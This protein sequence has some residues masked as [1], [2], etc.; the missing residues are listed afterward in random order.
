MGAIDLAREPASR[1]NFGPFALDPRR[2]ELTR[3]G[4]AVAL[5]PK[6]F[7]LLMYF[8]RRPGQALSKQ[9]LLAALWP[10]LVVSDD[11]LSQCVNE[12]RSV[13]DD[14][15]QGIIKTVSR[16]GY[17]FD[18]VVSAIADGADRIASQG[19]R[20]ASISASSDTRDVAA[21]LDG[22]SPAAVA[23]DAP[24][25]RAR[26]LLYA[27]G[28]GIAVAVMVTAALLLWMRKAP[29]GSIDDAVWARR[30]MAVIPFVEQG[31]GTGDYFAEAIT[32]DLVADLA[33]LPQTY[34]VA[35]ASAAAVRARETDI[36]KIGR[37]LG[38]RY[39]LSGSVR[40]QGAAVRLSAQ[41]AA[42]DNGAVLWSE[43]FDYPNAADWAWERDIGL[44]IART[45]D[46][47][48][49]AVA[50]PARSRSG[51]HLEA[52]DAVMRGAY[53][54]RHS[55]ARED[56][57]Q[58][59]SDFE[60][61]LKI[62]PDSPGALSGY[63]LAT[64]SWVTSRY[65]IDPKGDI[66]LAAKAI[67]RALTIDPDY[68]LAHFA[69]GHVLFM[70]GDLDGALGEYQRVIASNPSDA[71]SHA[72]IGLVMLALGRLEEV[73]PQIALA[74]RLNPL[75]G[76]QVSFGHYVAGVAEFQLGHEDAAYDRMRKAVTA[77]PNLIQGWA[78]MAAID[79]LQGRQAQATAEVDEIRRRR[80]NLTIRSV[81]GSNGERPPAA[82]LQRGD[83]R[84]I[85][86]L[87][88]AGLPE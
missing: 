52:V 27:A 74:Q 82:R 40:R 18:A 34:V 76:L 47:R 80:P 9:E 26:R 6:T 5:R 66:Q 56:L 32:E 59:R 38:V 14:R 25:H 30:S 77:N 41:F 55:A 20:T 58:A 11:S 65:S 63:A 31:E 62:D 61:A 19:D 69:H 64:L 75:E 87:K 17:R 68:T 54:T 46:L 23:A 2:V 15:E 88:K 39:V 57:L 43:Q 53:L 81:Q 29:S 84:F 36:R 83:L 35:R 28:G 60:S 45:L 13:L 16:R 33:R 70:R 71:W 67:D 37:E 22:T 48:L 7:A 10:G 8:A 78:W 73:A 12:L 49:T 44:R 3:D 4:V 79:A 1:L 72:R 51:E 21:H 50:A 85:D 86:G 42:T 24:P